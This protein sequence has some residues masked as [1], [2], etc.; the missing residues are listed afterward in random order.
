M[1]TNLM[2]TLIVLFLVV[3]GFISGKF[4][5]GQVAMTGMV[6][7]NIS[8][9]LSFSDAFAYLANGNL[10]MI[11]GMFIMSGAL[12]KTNL[13]PNLR[14]A[15]LAHS[16]S[17]KMI[18]WIYFIACMILI[19]VVLPTPLIGMM[20]PF[21]AV[22]DDD[23]PVKPSQLLLA[24]TVL[25]FTV[26]GLTPLGIGLTFYGMFNGFLEAAGAPERLSVLD[27]GKTLLIPAIIALL[28]YALYGWKRFSA[29]KITDGTI[30]A[31]EDKTS[32][33]SSFQENAVYIVFV[34]VIAGMI[35]GDRLGISISVFPVVG[36]LVFM[37]LGILDLADVRNNLNLDVCFMIVGIM[38]IATAV[39][40]TGAG[41]LLANGLITAL[42]GNPHPLLVLTV[43]YFAGAALSQFMSNIATMNIFIPIAV[44]TAISQGIDP[45][46]FCLAIAAGCNA[47]MLT[48][49]ASPSTAVAF[50]AGGN[51]IKDVLKVNFPLW[52]IYGVAVITMVNLIY[53][54]V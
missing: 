42:G 25:A 48:P 38:G 12:S 52:I 6:I 35:A 16:G 41:N 34:L 15:L 27:Y 44:V 14:K 23:G 22:L 49:A 39:Q 50:A 11:A 53:P 20:L 26:Q 9:V 46:P 30:K 29:N 3:A 2:I 40:A 5:L 28:Y 1:D 24:G 47:A 31:V 18:I 32:V 21:M 54:L 7:L 8:G 43:F 37:Y 51:K 13:I 33:L 10:V 17:G 4:K 45:R 36:A 19:Q